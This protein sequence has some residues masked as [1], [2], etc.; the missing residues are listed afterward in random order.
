MGSVYKRGNVW[1]I[2]FHQDGKAYFE[3]SRSKKKTTALNLLKRRE[4]EAERGETPGIHY[5]RTTYEELRDGFLWDR[6]VNGKGVKEAGYR[7]KHLGQFFDGL[8]ATRITSNMVTDYI[9]QRL[10]E[11]AANATVN[12][13]LAALKRMFK[14]GAIQRPAKVNLAMVPHISMLKEDNVRKGFFEYENF[15]A[16]EEALPGYL[17]PIVRFAYMTGW[18][19]SEILSLT[20]AQVDLQ[21]GAV[22]LE[23][24][25]TKNKRGRT[26]YL[27][28]SLLAEVAQQR[29]RQ[30][31]AGTI[32]KFVFPGPDGK[33]PVRD[34][35][36]SWSKACKESGQDGSTTLGDQRSVTW[37]G[38]GSP[39]T[40][41]CG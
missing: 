40:R 35:R 22:R 32:T 36:G 17:K 28:E 16:L 29:E 13:E 8:R 18:R 41:R 14:L 30:K 19:K 23:P 21:E 24:G 9:K 11:G 4:G 3:S 6:E 20:W 27:D 39:S 2:K 38:A 10:D 1:W 34:F 15:L 33:T 31:A 5:D 12:R 26:I 7:L 37:S 25:T